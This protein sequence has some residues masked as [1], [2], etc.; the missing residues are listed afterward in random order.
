MLLIFSLGLP[1]VI[2]FNLVWLWISLWWRSRSSSTHQINPR[3]TSFKNSLARV[4]SLLLIVLRRVIFLPVLQMQILTLVSVLSPQSEFQNFRLRVL[5]IFDQAPNSDL[6]RCSA[7]ILIWISISITVSLQFYSKLV[8]RD[9]NPHSTLAFAGNFGFY[10]LLDDL[11]K[12]LIAIDT[13]V[14]LKVRMILVLFLIFVRLIIGG[15]WC[16]GML[17]FFFM[18]F[19]RGSEPRASSRQE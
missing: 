13:V 2:A 1:I 3:K 16:S 7:C 15:I 18:E 14:D 5:S 8:L 12:I 17:L 19:L 9:D 10:T 11:Y 6:I 4:S